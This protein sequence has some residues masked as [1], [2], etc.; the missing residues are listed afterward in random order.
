MQ[1]DKKN[2]KINLP[3]FILHFGALTCGLVHI[4]RENG[5]DMNYTIM[6]SIYGWL[7]LRNFIGFCS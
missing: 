2:M 4:I 6:C 7:T 5:W 3:L 1:H